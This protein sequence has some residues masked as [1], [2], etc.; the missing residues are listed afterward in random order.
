MD[1]LEII[2]SKYRV[3]PFVVWLALGIAVG[4]FDIFLPPYPD[5]AHFISPS[6]KMPVAAAMFMAITFRG[7]MQLSK[8]E[9]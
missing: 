9:S 7:M 5:S 4:C 6:V 3:W 1:M 8:K 2:P